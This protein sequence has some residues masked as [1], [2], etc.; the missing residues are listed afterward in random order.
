MRILARELAV[1]LAT[2]VLTRG[3]TSS[4]KDVLARSAGARRAEL[5]ARFAQA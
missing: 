4:D 1:P 3:L 2:L 5:L